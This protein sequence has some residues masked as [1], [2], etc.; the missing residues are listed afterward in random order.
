MVHFVLR[1]PM[2]HEMSAHTIPRVRADSS[3]RFELKI[4]MR[5]YFFLVD[6]AVS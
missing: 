1:E 2:V 6:I 5:R 3:S 4:A